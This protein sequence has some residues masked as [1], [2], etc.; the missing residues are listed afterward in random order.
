[1]VKIIMFF[2]SAQDYKRA[3]DGDEGEQTEG[4]QLL[5]LEVQ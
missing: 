3:L 1:M 5:T 2:N 4:E